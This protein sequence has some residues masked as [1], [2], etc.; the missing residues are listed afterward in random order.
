VYP[1]RETTSGIPSYVPMRP[2]VKRN[3]LRSSSDVC[4]GGVQTIFFSSSRLS[5]PWTATLWS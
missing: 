4:V 3:H 2:T 1:V 5:G